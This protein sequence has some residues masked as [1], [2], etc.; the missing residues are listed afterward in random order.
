MSL[1][2][3][4]KEFLRL[5]LILILMLVS[6]LM[7]GCFQRGKSLENFKNSVLENIEDSK[8][9]P[10]SKISENHEGTFNDDST[11]T[12]EN[13]KSRGLQDKKKSSPLS[14]VLGGRRPKKV[15]IPTD[16]G[17]KEGLDI[18]SDK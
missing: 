12:S 13:K 7:T 11:P 5:I 10:V 4:F 2:K 3:I 8:E 17:R 6:F 1:R 14:E 18:F 16:P 15:E 9:S